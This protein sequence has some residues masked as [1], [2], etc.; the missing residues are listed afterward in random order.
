MDSPAYAAE[1]AAKDPALL[2]SHRRKMEILFAI[3]LGIFLSAL[4]QT[5]VGTALPA[6]S[7]ISRARTSC[8]RGSSPST[9]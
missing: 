1:Q 6:S 4:D 7:R 2:L 8:T 9:C 5:I 3:L